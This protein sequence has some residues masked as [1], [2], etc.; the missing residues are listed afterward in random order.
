MQ[1]VTWKSIATF[2][3]LLSLILA[4]APGWAQD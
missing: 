1:S 4:P 2:G 3:C